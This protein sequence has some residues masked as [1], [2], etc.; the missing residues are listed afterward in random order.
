MAPE[1]LQGSSYTDKVDVYSFGVLFNELLGRKVPY[2]GSDAARV[3]QLVLSGQRP[4]ICPSLPRD[5]AA[6]IRSC[7]S[8]E[9]SQRPSV[10]EVLDSLLAM[11]AK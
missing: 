2:A 6:L 4:D 11:D 9:V 1:L 10:K 5:L 3:S 7:W 8:A